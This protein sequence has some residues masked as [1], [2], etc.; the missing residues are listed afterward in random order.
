MKDYYSLLGLERT[1]TKAE[2]K[3][4]YRLLATKFHPDKNSNPNS[5]EKFI[6][7]SEAYEVLSNKKS[8]A[9]YDLIR[10]QEQKQKKEST[11]YFTVNV[12]T[13]ES[14]RTR[15]NKSQQKRSIKYHQAKSEAKK[16]FQLV[17]ESFHIVS[18]YVPHL[19]GISL[20]GLIMS[21]LLSHLFDSFEK[22]LFVGV[23]IAVLIAAFIYS[24]FWILKDFFLEYKKDLE[25]FSIFYKISQKNANTISLSIF[26]LVLLL[27]IIFLKAYF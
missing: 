23:T 21:S 25:A 19:L 6:I 1:A 8:R 14:T 16:L 4:R 13:P 2:I 12:P 26:A 9:K 11:D 24:I 7:I 10:W 27:Y 17:M 15:K 3:T 20:L 22:G 18:R 5:A